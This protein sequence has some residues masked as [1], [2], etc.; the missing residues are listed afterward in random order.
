MIR[1]SAGT[2]SWYL[3]GRKANP[4]SES[5]KKKEYPL[6]ITVRHRP[7]FVVPLL[8]TEPIQVF[9]FCDIRET[10]PRLE[11]EVGSWGLELLVNI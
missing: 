6:P 7:V 8:K 2:P 11:G 9:L 1:S 3:V 10:A 5:N 4:S